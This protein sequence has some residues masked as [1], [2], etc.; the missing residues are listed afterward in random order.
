M[1]GKGGKAPGRGKSANGGSSSGGKAHGG[2]RG[3]AMSAK[4]FIALTM[5]SAAQEAAA[6]PSR[7]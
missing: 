7:T 6:A 4:L 1:S 2:A 3:V 5:I